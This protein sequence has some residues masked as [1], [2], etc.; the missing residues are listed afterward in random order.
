[1]FCFLGCLRDRFLSVSSIKERDNRRLPWYEG[2]PFCNKWTTRT[3]IY[4]R[5]GREVVLKIGERPRD[6]LYKPLE[7][8]AQNFANEVSAHSWL[9]SWCCGDAATP[10]V[11]VSTVA[12]EDADLRACHSPC[13]F[14]RIAKNQ[15]FLEFKRP[16]SRPH[17][18]ETG[19]AV[20]LNWHAIVPS[21]TATSPPFPTPL[22][23]DESSLSLNLT[24][25]HPCA[26]ESGT[27]YEG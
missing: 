1:M 16:K 4:P 6:Q 13:A 17:T 19:S 2:Q 22:P 8:R 11:P 26:F 24:R 27:S 25:S 21:S 18:L 15:L 23:V 7:T 12:A 20:A 5:A 3:E 9:R 14:S 10:R